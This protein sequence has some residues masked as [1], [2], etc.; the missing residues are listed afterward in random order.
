M[1]QQDKQREIFNN[2][3]KTHKGLLFKVV[4]AYGHTVDDRDDLFQEISIQ[5]WNSVPNFRQESAETTWIYRVAL[6]TAMGWSRKQN[7]DNI[8]EQSFNE[9]EHML[10]EKAKE[11]DSRLE[12]LYEQ[13]AGLNAID[14]SLTLLLLEGYSYREMSSILGISENNVGVKINRIKKYFAQ[15]S[16]EL[17]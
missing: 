4:R 11:Q 10:I 17:K 16:Q 5:L 9:T 14:R 7:R 3:L 13:I 1:M 15:K 2:W 6:F 12:W 8:R